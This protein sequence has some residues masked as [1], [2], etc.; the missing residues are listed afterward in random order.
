MEKKRQELLAKN[1]EMVDDIGDRDQ[2]DI[3][4]SI[5]ME[6]EKRPGYADQ[7]LKQKLIE[8]K[9][10]APLQGTYYISRFDSNKYSGL[11]EDS[12]RSNFKKY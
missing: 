5:F 7:I 11:M 2:K 1:P 9:L 8:K 3:E 6:S 10:N 12:S 4:Y